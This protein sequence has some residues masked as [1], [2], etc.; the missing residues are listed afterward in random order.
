[1]IDGK[2]LPV[3]VSFRFYFYL[4]VCVQDTR[5]SQKKVSDSMARV[6]HS[7]ELPNVGSGD[8]TPVFCK[9]LNYF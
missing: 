1:M 8:Q 3:S 4:C 7:Y 6:I 2:S 9:G 5:R